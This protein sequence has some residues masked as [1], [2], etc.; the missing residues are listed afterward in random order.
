METIDPN[1]NGVYNV[2]FWIYFED[3][4]DDGFGESPDSFLVTITN[5]NCDLALLTA[6]AMEKQE[7]TIGD[8]PLDY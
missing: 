4:A 3:Y 7:Y 8:A 1:D 2:G 5:L 6:S